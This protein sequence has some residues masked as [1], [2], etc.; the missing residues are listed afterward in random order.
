MKNR[1]SSYRVVPNE[2]LGSGGVLSKHISRPFAHRWRSITSRKFN[3]GNLN[4]DLTE[5]IVSQSEEKEGKNKRNNYCRKKKRFSDVDDAI[6]MPE[7]ESPVS[8]PTLQDRPKRTSRNPVEVKPRTNHPR[9][10]GADIYVLRLGRQGPHSKDEE[11]TCCVQAVEGDV[12]ARPTSIPTGSLHEQLIKKDTS[13][14]LR[15]HTDCER[16][17]RH[18]PVLSSRPCYRCVLYMAS[19]GIKRVF[20]T[21]SLGGW[22]GAKV[23]DLVDAIDQ[24]GS[25]SEDD[26]KFA[27][28]LVFVTKHEVLMLRRVMCDR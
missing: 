21:N 17:D 20:W 23:R 12:D 9:L 5:K 26:S 4:G 8:G 6:Q 2:K 25:E 28:S 18:P 22:E 1:A 24:L 15:R 3:S 19:A 16:A 7:S 11:E 14:D 13:E 10:R 27:L